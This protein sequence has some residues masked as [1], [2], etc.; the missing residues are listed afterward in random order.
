MTLKPS[1]IVYVLFLFILVL[2]PSFSLLI[3]PEKSIDA[4]INMFIGIAIYIFIFGYFLLRDYKTFTWS[5]STVEIKYTFI[6]FL[7]PILKVHAVNIQKVD[8][9]KY[10][11]QYNL[12]PIL[13]ISYKDKSDRCATKKI[14]FRMELQKAD[15]QK[16]IDV[17]RL[18]GI[19]INCE[20]DIW[21]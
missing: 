10:A 15:F 13:T 19:N 1:R 17:L 16:F 11:I 7:K 6:L 5:N 2:V 8:I 21:R 4:Y 14:K 9:V 20:G 12:A 3:S 18:N